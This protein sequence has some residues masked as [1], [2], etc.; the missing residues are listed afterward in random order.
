M[1]I[2]GIH[3]GKFRRILPGISPEYD[4]DIEPLA[5][6]EEIAQYEQ[7]VAEE[8]HNDEHIWQQCFNSE[9]T[10]ASCKWFNIYLLKYR[11]KKSPYNTILY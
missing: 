7:I 10:V 5:S 4:D 1:R 3:Y 11:N 9:V 2:V 6:P 8:E